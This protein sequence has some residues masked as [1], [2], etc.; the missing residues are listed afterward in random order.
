MTFI[1]TDLGELPDNWEPSSEEFKRYIGKAILFRDVQ[2]IVKADHSIT[3]Y[4]INI[5]IY[6]VSLLAEKTARRIDLEA[7]WKRQKIS[8]ALAAI[9]GLWS[10]VIFKALLEYSQQQT[11][12]VDNILK[13][14]AAWEYMLSLDLRLLPEAERELASANISPDGASGG[15]A[16]ER[17]SKPFS[18]EDHNNIAR[19]TELSA[20]Q[21]MSIVVWGNAS[22]TFEKWQLGLA[23]SLAGYAAQGWA[24][25]PSQKQ[26]KHGA[27]MIE[28]ARAAGA[29]TR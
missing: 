19:C 18:N 16:G 21:W 27:A 28:L 25:S 29:L 15:G 8:N 14:Q 11:V 7:I 10:P 20:D 3:A 23:T 17:Y 6:T 24:K 13:S 26:A 4:R 5:T 1:K 22:G 12:H 9:A 2:G